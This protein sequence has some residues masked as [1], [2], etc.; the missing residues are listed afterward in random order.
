MN[1]LH[2]A[3]QLLRGIAAALLLMAVTF[4]TSRAAGA[5]AVNTADAPRRIV[6]CETQ[7]RHALTGGSGELTFAPHSFTV[8][9]LE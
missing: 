9:R 4:G 5:D 8:V 1:I 3:A 7:W 6:P 2:A